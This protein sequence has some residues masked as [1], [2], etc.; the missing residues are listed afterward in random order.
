MY[1]DIIYNNPR[2]NMHDTTAILNEI[3]GDSVDGPYEGEDYWIEE[4]CTI[5]VAENNVVLAAT[6]LRKTNNSGLFE[7]RL[8]K[9]GQKGDSILLGFDTL[10][11]VPS[12]YTANIGY[13]RD[14]VAEVKKD[15]AGKFCIYI[16]NK[17]S[18]RMFG[19]L[20]AAKAYLNKLDLELQNESTES[21]DND[22]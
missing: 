20:P 18:T 16:N 4:D 19:K 10:E 13:K 17:R 14:T 12:V 21:E 6:I 2:Y 1:N 8:V 7:S 22:D 15:K 5:Q 11:D 3:I 9:L